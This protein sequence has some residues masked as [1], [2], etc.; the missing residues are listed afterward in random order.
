MSNKKPAPPKKAAKPSTYL[1]FP[2]FSIFHWGPFVF[3]SGGGGGKQY[4]LINRICCYKAAP[5][6]T[7]LIK[8]LD[9]DTKL[10]SNMVKAKRGKNQFAVCFGQKVALFSIDGKTGDF[11]QLDE[12][13]ADFVED[14]DLNAIEYSIDNSMIVTGGDDGVARVWSVSDDGKLNMTKQLH[15]HH[16]GISGVTINPEM[17]TVISCSKDK[18]ARIYNLEKGT[19]VKR[20][21][22]GPSASTPNLLFREIIWREKDIVTLLSGM[23]S[24][25]VVT[26]DHTKDFAPLKY[27]QVHNKAACSMAVLGDRIAVGTNDGYVVQADSNLEVQRVEKLHKMPITSISYTE[28][29]QNVLTSSADYTY[30]F[31]SLPGSSL[32]N[33]VYWT[34]MISLLVF[35]IVSNLE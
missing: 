29:G 21:S 33:L 23:K 2:L 14:G 13:Q 9:T 35:F 16:Q 6:L 25:Y 19:C 34:I 30:K 22:F 7:E 24:T 32:L 18:T 11:D 17:T 5:V 31:V 1:D 15:S 8:E 28:S 12:K 20:L 4:G 3:V 27:G 10:A 26:W